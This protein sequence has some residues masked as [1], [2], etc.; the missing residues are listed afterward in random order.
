MRKPT[1]RTLA[2]SRET[3]RHLSSMSLDQIGGAKNVTAVSGKPDC[4]S[5]DQC[6]TTT[7]PQSTVFCA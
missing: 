1:K 3:V 4:Q 5:V 7:C 6:P 2:L